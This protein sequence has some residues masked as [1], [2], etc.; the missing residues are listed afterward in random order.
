MVTYI[1][2]LLIASL[3][4]AGV[5]TAVPPRARIGTTDLNH[6]AGAGKVSI[7]Q[8]ARGK[9]I[10]NGAL[11]VKETYLKF[12]IP[13]PEYLE[14]A[15]QNF[16]VDRRDTG[17]VSA[18]PIDEYDDAYVSPVSIGTPPQTLDLDFDTGSSD[19]WVFSSETPSTQVSGQSIYTPSKSSTAK[20]L[21][22]YT[23]SISYGDGSSSSGDVYTDTVTIGGLTVAS[24]AVEAAKKVSSSFTSESAI[25]GLVGLGFDSLNTV[26]PTAQ[27]TFFSTAKAQLD[28]PLFTA[29]LKYKAPG[30][31]NF[32][33]I[34]EAAYTGTITYVPV[35]TN[36]GYWTFTS[37]GYAVGTSS[38]VSTS[39]SGIADTGTTLLYLP[40][41]IVRAYYAQVTG[42][43]NSNTYGGYVFPCSATLPSFTFGVSGARIIIPAKYIN[44]GAVTTGSSTCFGGLQSS[45][46]IGINIFGDVALKAAFVVFNGASTPTLGW[47]NKTLA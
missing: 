19:F 3:V 46:G 10:F 38:F 1:D 40:A 29:D 8:V 45:A 18:N 2:F 28:E 6:N 7:K 30:T 24:Q 23:W 35:T 4:G 42:S 9:K 47:A 26:K 22:G 44:Y 16:A 20:S 37:S 43:S 31:Y 32:G 39:T 14:Q 34:D 11:S 13:V 21:S 17:S 27:K 12:G 5:G 33:Y 36:P 25:D 15:V 41:T